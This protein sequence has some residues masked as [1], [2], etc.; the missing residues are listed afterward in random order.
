MEWAQ[1]KLKNLVIFA[2]ADGK[3]TLICGDKTK[4]SKYE[5]R[6]KNENRLAK[7]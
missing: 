7:Y 6:T 1:N 2:K 3:T 4:G 5:K